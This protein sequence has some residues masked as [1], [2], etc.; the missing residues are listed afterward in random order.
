[1]LHSVDLG[2]TVLYSDENFKINSFC[3]SFGNF[4]SQQSRVSVEP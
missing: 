4:Y 1:M 2:I 3:N